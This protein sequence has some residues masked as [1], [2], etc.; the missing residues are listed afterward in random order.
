VT[1]RLTAIVASVSVVSCVFIVFRLGFWLLG[2]GLFLDSASFGK[3]GQ[4][5]NGFDRFVAIAP[6]CGDN[7]LRGAVVHFGAWC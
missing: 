2:L 4:P 6:C 5:V 1:P 3:I 7:V